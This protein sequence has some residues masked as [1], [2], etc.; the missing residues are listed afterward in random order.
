M[1]SQ[2][3]LERDLERWFAS[4]PTEVADRARDAFRARIAREEQ[5]PAWRSRWTWRGP[6]SGTRLAMAVSGVAVAVVIG[7]AWFRW[8][9]GPSVGITPVTPPPPSV[10]P[11]PSVSPPPPSASPA[12]TSSVPAFASPG[13]VLESGPHVS[14]TFADPFAF[15]TPDGWLTDAESK[16]SYVLSQGPNAPDNIEILTDLYPPLIDA[17]GCMTEVRWDRPHAAKD[18][19]DH[20]LAYPGFDATASPITMARLE[21]WRIRVSVKPGWERGCSGDGSG[22]P[23][24]TVHWA[25]GIPVTVGGSGVNEFVALDGHHGRTITIENRVSD[26]A[27]VTE[28][29]AIVDSIQFAP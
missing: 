7:L 2:Q 20:T 21:G 18:L 13:V 22:V 3:D 28:A 16:S 8:T 17:K 23:L 27:L 25:D 24:Y 9:N 26:P 14:H 1:T 5:R 6:G 11:S 4:G 19:V 15:V 29:A 10:E 12:A